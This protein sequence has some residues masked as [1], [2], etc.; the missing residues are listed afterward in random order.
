VSLAD[1]SG[2]AICPNASKAFENYF[3]AL[4]Y[5]IYWEGRLE[6]GERWYE[7]YDDGQ[8]VFQISMP[9]PPIAELREDLPKILMGE[10]TDGPTVY[11]IACPDLGALRELLSRMEDHSSEGNT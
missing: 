2:E 3:E 4:G 8:L 9:P 6:T 11:W 5:K 7:C 1:L 10:R